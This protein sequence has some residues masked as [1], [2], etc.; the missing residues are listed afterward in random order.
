M[1]LDLTSAYQQ[2]MLDEESSQLLTINTQKGLYRYTRMLFGV[3]SA[4]AIFQHTMDTIL[5]GLPQVFCYLDDILVTGDT[6]E[7]HLENLTKTQER[8]QQHG[9]REKFRFFQE[10]VEYLKHVLSSKGVHTFPEKVKAVL[11]Q[12]APQNVVKLRSFLGQINYYAKFIENLSTLLAPLH[13]LTC[14]DQPWNWTEECQR[15]FEEAK[16]QMSEAPV[17]AHFDPKPADASPYGVGA[18]ISHIMSDGSERPIAFASCTLL[19]GKRNYVQ[20]EKEVLGLI[21]GVKKFHQFLLITDHKPLTTILGPKCG[22]PPL[23]AARMQWWALLLSA[24]SYDIRYCSTITHGNADGLSHL[25]LRNS[26]PDASSVHPPS[27]NIGQLN[28]AIQ[29]SQVQNVTQVNPLLKKVLKYTKKGWSRVVPE[30]LR[31]FRQ[32]PQELSIE[33]HECQE[34]SLPRFFSILF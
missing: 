32:W 11:E 23:A 30:L 7:N 24:Y 8:L 29:S 31:P 1:K 25:P 6:D 21:F 34:L 12:P 10:S 18:V 17:L 15:A 28:A 26:T 2:M 20:I 13:H 5:Q 9:R 27:F 19:V 4:P 14:K 33:S 22:V 3:A 16:R